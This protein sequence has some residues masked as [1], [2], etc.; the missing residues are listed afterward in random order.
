MRSTEI[1]TLLRGGEHPRHDT[2]HIHE[3]AR[4]IAREQLHLATRP[5]RPDA[6]R[7][8]LWD[9][10]G[11]AYKVTARTVESSRPATTLEVAVNSDADHLLAVFL[12]RESYRLVEMVRIP[13]PTVLW[14]GSVSGGRVRLRWSPTSSAYGVAERL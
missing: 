2:R 6:S 13:W 7:D 3:L 8:L 12:E 11:N 10:A 4:A 14:L 9:R 5:A 1:R